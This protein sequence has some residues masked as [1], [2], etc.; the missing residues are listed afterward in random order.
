MV[1]T[2]YPKLRGR[3]VEKYGTI[4]KFASA[5]GRSGVNT[6]NKL[7]GKTGFS[8]SEILQWCK[9]LDIEIAEVGSFF[10]DINV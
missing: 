1:G 6:S 10:C 7:N 3:I 4:E 2:M 9:L 5:I 8:Q